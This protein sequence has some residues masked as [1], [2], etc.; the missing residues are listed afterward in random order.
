MSRR[1]VPNSTQIPDVIFDEWMSILTPAEFK[2]LCYIAR[3][4]FGF[5]KASDAISLAQIATGIVRKDGMRLDSGTGLNRDT[6]AAALQT[7]EAVGLLTRTREQNDHQG[8]LPTSYEINLDAETPSDSELKNVRRG[9]LAQNSDKGLPEKSDKPLAQN[10]DKGGVK[11]PTS[12]CRKNSLPL[13]Q[14][15]DKPLAQ[16]SDTQETVLQETV[17]ETAAAESNA[18]AAAA[19][20]PRVVAGIPEPAVPDPPLPPVPLLDMS[21]ADL[22]VFAKS[23]PSAL[24]RQFRREHPDYGEKLT[25]K[26]KDASKSP[27][28][29]V[30]PCIVKDWL[31]EIRDKRLAP[32]VAESRPTVHVVTPASNSRLAQYLT[33]QKRPSVNEVAQ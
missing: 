13:A 7:L 28:L 23:E 5:G 32:P 26:Q 20:I 16:N 3:R 24:V 18:T 29:Y 21:E 22:A 10:S 4:T 14:N 6:I 33:K 2:V 1:L 19:Y 25:A 9:G 30:I 8:N 31:P 27:Y 17:Q 15:S 12:P 11:N